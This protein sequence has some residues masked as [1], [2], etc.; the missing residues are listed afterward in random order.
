MC[1]KEAYAF[2]PAS[3]LFIGWSIGGIIVAYISDRIGRKRTIY[4]CTMITLV[5]AIMSAVVGNVLVY[6]IFRFII[7]FAL[8]GGPVT[9]CVLAAEIVGSKHRALSCTAMWIYYTF[10]LTILALTAYLVRNWRILELI[11]SVPFLLLVFS[12]KYVI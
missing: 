11:N 7:G 8:G 12:W 4:I 3:M 10:A 2:A 1:T 9:I 6:I 5:S